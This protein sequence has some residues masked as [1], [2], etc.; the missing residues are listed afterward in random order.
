M[1]LKKDLNLPKLN[2]PSVLSPHPFS[3]G[4]GLYKTINDDFHV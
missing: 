2:H 3:F 4:L 1:I